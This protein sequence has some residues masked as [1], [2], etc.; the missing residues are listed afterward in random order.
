MK[1]R[2]PPDE[3]L[4]LD[5]RQLDL[6]D[7]KLQNTINSL[8]ERVYPPSCGITKKGFVQSVPLREATQRIIFS[9]IVPYPPGVP[10]VWPGER[11]ST[12]TVYLLE[13]LLN[14]GFTIYGI[15]K[16]VDKDSG[17]TI[18]FVSCMDDDICL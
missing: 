2:P 7:K 14:Y 5:I 12:G 16:T 6:L 15:S 3:S 11:L 10:M 8:P 4:S 17:E 9:A 18:P 1:K 13:A